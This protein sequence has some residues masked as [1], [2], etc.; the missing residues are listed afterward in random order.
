MLDTIMRKIFGLCWRIGNVLR[1][2]LIRTRIPA[3]GAGSLFYGKITVRKGEGIRIGQHASFGD[4]VFLSAEGGSIAIEDSCVLLNEVEVTSLGSVEIGRGTTLNSH[5]VVKGQGVKLGN[6]VWV[7]QNCIIEG[8]NVSVCDRVIFGP[9]VHVNDGEHR[10]DPVTHEISMEPGE[11]RPIY[12]GENAWIGSG[13]MI[14]KGVHIGAGAIIGARSVVTKDVPAFTIAAGNP[15]RLIKNR[16][17]N[18]K[19]N[20]EK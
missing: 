5:V 15:A 19:L 16:L 14:L 12:I 10:I 7:A 2:C 11:S 17:T 3:V 4:R 9:Y 18:E 13:A 20:D 1:S 8:K 6:N